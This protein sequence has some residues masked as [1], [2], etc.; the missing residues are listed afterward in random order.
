MATFA[1]IHG[2]G[3]VGWY[4]HLVEP[5][6]RQRGHDVVAP[7]LP[8]DDDAPTLRDYADTVVDAIGDRRN[9]IVVAQSYGGVHRADRCR[10]AF[11]RRAGPCRR[12]GS[13][14][15]RES[16]GVVDEHPLP[17]GGGAACRA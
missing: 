13:D 9:V 16:G 4:W 1:L 11:G 3:D 10:S 8:C 7:D 14:T 2:G 12:H 15:W 6:L 5:V 17:P